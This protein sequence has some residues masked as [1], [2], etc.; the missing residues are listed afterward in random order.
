MPMGS[1]R[2]A[3]TRPT[4]RAIGWIWRATGRQEQRRAGSRRRD[5]V[6]GN[7]DRCGKRA[8]FA[9]QVMATSGTAAAFQRVNLLSLTCTFWS[10]R[11]CSAHCGFWTTEIG[12]L[13]GGCRLPVLPDTRRVASRRHPSMADVV[14]WKRR[15]DMAAMVQLPTG[16]V[17]GRGQREVMVGCPRRPRRAQSLLEPR[18]AAV[19]VCRVPRC[20]AG[21]CCAG[22][23][24][25]LRRNGSTKGVRSSSH[26]L[27]QKD[28]DSTA[29]NPAPASLGPP[30]PQN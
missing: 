2:R 5:V 20:C 6:A 27:Y 24:G 17:R 16:G 30:S 22:C 29:L 3:M 26:R 10:R 7:I 11:P 9:T 18:R 8:S 4:I 14:G 12:P 15:C 25:E 19:S 23:P 13:R 28:P 21:C 1:G